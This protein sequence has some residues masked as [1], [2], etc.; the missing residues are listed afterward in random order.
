MPARGQRAVRR[1]CH[2]HSRLAFALQR[3]ELLGRRGRELASGSMW[4]THWYAAEAVVKR[5]ERERNNIRPLRSSSGRSC[6]DRSASLSSS[7][8]DSVSE[9]AIRERIRGTARRRWHQGG[10]RGPEESSGQGHGMTLAFFAEIVES[11]HATLSRAHVRCGA[12]VAYTRRRHDVTPPPRR[13]DAGRPGGCCDDPSPTRQPPHGVI[14][15][16]VGHCACAPGAARRAPLGE[17][18]NEFSLSALKFYGDL[19]GTY[20]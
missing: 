19:I 3:T 15:S 6:V 16:P 17:I 10:R 5:Q 7:S 8:P 9:R 11:L 12:S 18:W 2:S 20:L 4:Y 14:I 1:A 13:I